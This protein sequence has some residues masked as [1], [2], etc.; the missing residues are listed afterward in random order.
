MFAG[1]VVSP[2]QKNI[3]TA[4]ETKIRM[5]AYPFNGTGQ[6]YHIIIHNCSSKLPYEMC[7]VSFVLPSR[8]K[9]SS[10]T[11]A[12]RLIPIVVKPIKRLRLGVRRRPS[13]KVHWRI[14]ESEALLDKTFKISDSV[15]ALQVEG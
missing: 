6:P 4:F 9:R 2:T 1:D 14:N 7:Q 10:L 8:R 5:K 11:T 12:N 15:A 13:G 3:D